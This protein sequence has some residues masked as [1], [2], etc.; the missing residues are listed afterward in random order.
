M[1]SPCKKQCNLIKGVCRGCGRTLEQIANWTKYSDKQRE[2]IIKSL[3][4]SE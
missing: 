4:K 2:I 1:E 3:D